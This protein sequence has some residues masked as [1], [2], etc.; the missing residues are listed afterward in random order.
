MRMCSLLAGL[1]VLDPRAHLGQ[2]ADDQSSAQTQRERKCPRVV[3]LAMSSEPTLAASI[4]HRWAFRGLW[5]RP[6][7]GRCSG[8][9]RS[10]AQR[11]TQPEARQ[12]VGRPATST[13]RLR[14]A[15]GGESETQGPLPHQAITCIIPAN[16]AGPKMLPPPQFLVARLLA[17]GGGQKLLNRLPTTLHPPTFDKMVSS[18]PLMP[19]SSSLAGPQES[20]SPP[21]ASCF[22]RPPGRRG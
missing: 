12:Q 8:P 16:P 17:R 3:R 22:P 11:R 2:V 15:T 7:N 18:S 6:H 20:P 1:E 14:G 19:C 9:S 5:R 4:A 10:R 13:H 21:G